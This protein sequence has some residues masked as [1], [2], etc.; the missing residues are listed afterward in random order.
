M[1]KHHLAI[2]A[3]LLS[4]SVVPGA[5]AQANYA[6]GQ[7]YT[8]DPPL[9]TDWLGDS[10]GELTDG[11]TDW[12]WDPVTG[13]DGSFSSNPRS[14]VI[15]LGEVKG[16]IGTVAVTVF[17]SA[18]SAVAPQLQILVLGSSTSES[19]GFVEWG[20]AVTQDAGEEDNRVHAWAGG[21]AAAR[22]VKIVLD[23]ETPGFHSLLS[24]IQVLQAAGTSAVTDWALYE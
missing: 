17:V 15:D 24:E 10:G 1:R 8:A 13:W 4:V 16:D 23:S 19:E 22:W 21:P 12:G 7:S 11:V 9:R 5:W 18:G 6:A 2:A 3:V 14:L 20:E